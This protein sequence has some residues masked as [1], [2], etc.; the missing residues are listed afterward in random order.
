MPKLSSSRSLRCPRRPGTTCSSCV[1]SLPVNLR[2]GRY[3]HRNALLFAIVT[4]NDVITFTLQNGMS[5]PL[6]L[7]KVSTGSVRLWPAQSGRSVGRNTRKL[8]SLRRES[9]GHNGERLGP[10]IFNSCAVE[11]RPFV[12]DCVAASKEH[13]HGKLAVSS[14]CFNLNNLFLVGSTWN[15]N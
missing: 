4:C 15:V 1:G 10:L 14:L 11:L 12:V 7:R 9:F 2:R 5:L 3:R 8:L 13:A 6:C